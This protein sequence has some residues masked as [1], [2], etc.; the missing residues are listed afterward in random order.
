MS[1]VYPPM[2]KNSTSKQIFSWLTLSYMTYSSVVHCIIKLLNLYLNNFIIADIFNFESMF[3]HFYSGHSYNLKFLLKNL[4]FFSV[5]KI[6]F[7][8]SKLS[9]SNFHSVL[10][11]FILYYYI[12]IQ[13]SQSFSPYYHHLQFTFLI[14]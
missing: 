7:N 13:Y 1:F 9:F 4:I 6:V 11:C 10:S 14:F 3:P 12:F 5:L 2:I 8:I